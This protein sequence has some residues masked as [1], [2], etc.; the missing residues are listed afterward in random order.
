MDYS[1]S[2]KANL[3]AQLEARDQAINL[4]GK[5]LSERKTEWEEERRKLLNDL[6]DLTVKF[7]ELRHERMELRNINTTFLRIIDNVTKAFPS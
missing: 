7:N 1:K 6:N 5:T 3:I 4:M 2:T